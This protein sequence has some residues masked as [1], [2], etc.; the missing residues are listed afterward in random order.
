M[1]DL[2]FYP[3]PPDLARRAWKKF[4]NKCFERVLDPSAG[5]GDLADADARKDEW[6]RRS[7]K[8]DCIEI[9]ISRHAT[10]QSKG[11]KVVGLDFM[12]FTSG[13]IYSHI[14]MNPPFAVGAKHVLK[15]W[16]ILW[17]G[18]IVAHTQ[19]CP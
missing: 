17:D 10:L 3:T 1:D 14:I 15:A 11:L 9:D 12:T 4:K 7:V 16:D 6:G 2:Q 13:A 5:N 8:P 19:V 18:E